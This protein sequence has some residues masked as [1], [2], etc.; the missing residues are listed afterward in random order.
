MTARFV[1][2]RESACDRRISPLLRFFVALLLRMTKR[3]CNPKDYVITSE[4]EP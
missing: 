4:E 2:L 1:I 3:I